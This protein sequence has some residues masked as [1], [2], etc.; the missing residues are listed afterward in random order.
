[1]A[2]VASMAVEEGADK[3]VARVMPDPSSASG[4]LAHAP[5]N[6]PPVPAAGHSVQSVETPGTPDRKQMPLSPTSSSQV[7]EV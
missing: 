5:D 2:P 1:M 3:P 6:A 4:T 7:Q